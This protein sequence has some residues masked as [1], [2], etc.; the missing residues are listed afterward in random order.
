MD[1]LI[2]DRLV[3]IAVTKLVS[4]VECD[5]GGLSPSAVESELRSRWVVSELG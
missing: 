5:H 2:H 3:R 1:P 4:E